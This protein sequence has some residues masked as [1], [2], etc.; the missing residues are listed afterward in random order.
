[1]PFPDLVANVLC[2]E[3]VNTVN[4][5]HDPRRDLL[6]D[7]DSTAEWAALAG[8]PLD[9]RPT[10][11]EA[12]RARRLRSE[13]RE[14][15]RAVAHGEP[16]RADGLAA[17]LEAHR[18]GLRSATLEPDAGRTAYRLHWPSPTD[19]DVVV[20]A[21]AASAT[22][23]LAEGPLDRVGECPSCGWLYLDTSRNGRRRWCSMQTCG[24][25]DKARAYYERH[26]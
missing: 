18:R 4:N 9:R 13:V 11:A 22:R 15:F 2:L 23:L 21:V 3:L 26:R 20:A 17:V 5:W 19:L 1:M 7:A 8:I 24:A 14:V 6:D 10:A 12:G 16:A 25:R